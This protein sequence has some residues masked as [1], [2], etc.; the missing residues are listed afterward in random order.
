VGQN[1]KS[2]SW[3]FVNK[4]GSQAIGFLGNILIA[5]QLSPDDYGLVGMLAIFIA[6]SWSFAESGLAD[7]LL[8]RPDVDS[9]DTSTVFIFNLCI[10]IIF[11]GLLF[12]LAPIISNFYGRYELDEILKII[13][14]SLIF[15]ALSFTELIMLQKELQFKT[16]AFLNLSTSFVSVVISYSMALSGWGYWSLVFQNISIPITIIFL[17]TIIYGW[18]PSFRFSYKRFKKM[19]RF[20]FNMLFAFIVNQ[21]GKNIYSSFIGKIYSP[22]DLGLYMQGTK[23]T[24]TAFQSINSIILGTSYSLIAKEQQRTRRR[25][26]YKGVLNHFLFIHFVISFFIIGASQSLLLLVFGEKWVAS[27]PYLQ[28]LTIS[29]FLQPLTTINYNMIKIAGKTDIYRNLTFLSVGFNLVVLLFTYQ[30]SIEVI[31]IGQIGARYMSS[32]ID[33]LIC[34][35]YGEVLPTVQLFIAIKQFWIPL[36]SCILA[37]YIAHN[38]EKPIWFLAIFSLTYALLFLFTNLLFRNTVMMSFLTK[39]KKCV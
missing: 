23:I 4:I 28:L 30:Y 14:L 32:I 8:S 36:I 6:I 5:R 2:Y 26:M 11:Y 15:R 22:K 19:S 9:L 24:D 29:L 17:L 35:K 12:F 38:L 33:V 10:A 21:V 34:G 25:E 7:Y 27:T 37:F 13:G 3:S 31:I 18:R 16:L 1:L 39:L 20:G